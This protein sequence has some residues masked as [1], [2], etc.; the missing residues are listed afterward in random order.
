MNAFTGF[1]P[2]AFT[3][4]RGLARNNKKEWFEAHRDDYETQVRAPMRVLVDEIDAVLGDIAPEMRGDAKKS[5]FRIHR[6]IR[7]SSDKSPYKT[8]IAAWFFHQDAGSGVGREAHGGA[9]YYIH[10]EPGACMFGG[11]IWMPPKF[12]L[13]R[14]RDQIVEDGATF[15]K[16]VTAPA[17]KRR[18]GALSTEALLTRTPRGYD[19][20]H[21]HEK[22]LRY[23]SFTA[24]KKL[25]DTAVSSRKLL[26]A[27]RSDIAAMLPFVRWLN[28]AIGLASRKSR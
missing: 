25:S 10:V 8:H 9:G 17:F 7:F 3:F 19:A 2:R 14:I 16:L 4:L 28:G 23:K 5:V 18:F 11:G 15:E 20:A 21:P 6:D 1:G 27:M 13:D 22:W 26:S 12:A 24:G